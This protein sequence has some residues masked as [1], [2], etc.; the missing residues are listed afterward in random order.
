MPSKKDKGGDK[1]KDDLAR[2]RRNKRLVQEHFDQ[3]RD[4]LARDPNRDR[5]D[6]K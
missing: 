6:D 4:D 1:P 3:H 2:R 5:K